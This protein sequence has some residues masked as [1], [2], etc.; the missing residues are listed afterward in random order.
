MLTLCIDTAYKYLSCCL[1]ENENIIC[2][3]NEICYKKQSEQLFVV[4]EHLLATSNKKILDIDSICISKGP[5]SYTG[6]R[7][8]MTL[9]KV[10]CSLKKLDL[11]VIS[12]LKLYSDNQE[13]C[14][15][16]MDA[17][18]NRAYYGIYNKGDTIKED[19]VAEIS[20]I[21]ISGYKV[22]GD[23]Q[24]LGKEEIMP[25]ISASFLHLKSKWEKVSDVDHL[26]PAY[27]KESEAY[28]R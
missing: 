21:D 9:A 25:L 20:S 14:L 24:L 19:S 18:A 13:N 1:I 16:I 8:A 5:G 10:I 27:L 22:I 11:Y 3:Y 17:R 15:V 23:G 26:I 4:L 7:I 2:E 12:T 28:K 6:V